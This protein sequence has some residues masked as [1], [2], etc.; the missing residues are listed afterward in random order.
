[1][2]NLTISAVAACTVTPI[3]FNQYDSAVVFGL[4]GVAELGGKYDFLPVKGNT[5]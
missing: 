4:S 2:V 3:H 1:M 5:P